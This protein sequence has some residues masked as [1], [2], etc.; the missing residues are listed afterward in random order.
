MEHFKEY[1][2]FIQKFDLRVIETKDKR[3]SS[4]NEQVY[5]AGYDIR[6]QNPNFSFQFPGHLRLLKDLAIVDLIS[7]D[8]DKRLDYLI[9]VEKVLTRFDDFWK[10]YH[11]HYPLGSEPL[12]DNF[13]LVIRFGKIFHTNILEPNKTDIIVTWEFVEDLCDSV[14]EREESL[15]AFVK[16]IFQLESR[17]KSDS[18]D[19]K[20]DDTPEI[21][22]ELS[23]NKVAVNT[24]IK[25]YPVFVE[26]MYDQFFKILKEYFS[27]EQQPGLHSLLKDNVLPKDKLL[28]NSN[29]NQLA[30]AFKQLIEANFIVSC[31]KA[32]LEGWIIDNFQYASNSQA[33]PFTAGYLNGIISSDVKICK[34]PILAIMNDGSG[35]TILVAIARSKRRSDV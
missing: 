15:A 17:S 20:I 23:N 21:V 31:T 26:G 29:G 18:E 9:Q 3:I 33:K 12:K 30:D 25:R 32:E 14:R 5:G 10:N 35:I 4:G 27:A 22:S 7:A 16:E 24:K 6:H 19:M 34:S 1:L 11:N 28:F 13:L 2:T 8:E